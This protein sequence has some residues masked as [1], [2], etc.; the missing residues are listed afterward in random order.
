MSELKLFVKPGDAAQAKALATAVREALS[1]CAG[2]EMSIR[3]FPAWGEEAERVGV[4]RPPA[5]AFGD[6]V[7]WAGSL[8]DPQRLASMLRSRLRRH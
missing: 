3:E 2:R 7:I 8:P 6:E 1:Q 5:V 4:L